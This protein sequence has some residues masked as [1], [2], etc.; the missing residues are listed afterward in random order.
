MIFIFLCVVVSAIA[1]ALMDAGNFHPSLFTLPPWWGH[2]WRNK[3]VDGDPEKGRIKWKILFLQFNKPVQLSDGWHFSKFVF[4]LA[5]ISAIVFG[6]TIQRG[7]SLLQAGGLLLL[8]GI[9]WNTSFMFFYTKI[10]RR[11]G[12]NNTRRLG[13]R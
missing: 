5:N 2:N 3:Y 12:E 8:L 13:N 11:N 7:V 10:F 9:V 4:V 6:M 1:N